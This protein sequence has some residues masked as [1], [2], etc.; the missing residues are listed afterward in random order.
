MFV[1]TVVCKT[2][3]QLNPPPLPARMRL[4]CRNDPIHCLRSD[5]EKTNQQQRHRKSSS[6]SMEIRLMER[7]L[8]STCLEIDRFVTKNRFKTNRSYNRLFLF[9]KA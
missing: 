6:N 3:M 5:N 7:V 2:W 4:N 1:S 8:C 9:Y